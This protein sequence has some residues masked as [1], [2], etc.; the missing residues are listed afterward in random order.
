ML[1]IV[2]NFNE[3]KNSN[4]L[5]LLKNRFD[6]E[7]YNFLNLDQNILNKIEKIFLDQKNT[8]LKIFLWNDKFEEII[9]LF[10]LDNS[11]DILLFLWEN[12]S[13]IPEKISFEYEKDNF[14]LDSIILWKYDFSNYKAEKKQ[15]ELNLLCENSKE[16]FLQDRLSTLK[17][18]TDARDIVNTPSNDKTCDKY[19]RHIKNIKFKNTKVKV[20][21]YEELK[22]SW[23]WLIEA[24]WRSSTSKPKIVILENIIDKRLPTIWLVWKWIIFDTGWLNIK[25]ENYMYWMKDDMA[26]S[27][28]LLYTM[29]ELDDKKLWVNIVCALSI[30]ENSISWDSYR[31]WDILTS[32]SW[33]T[34]EVINTDAEWRL[35]MADWISYLSKNYNLES[36]T[37]L[38]TLTWA[39]MVALWYNYAWVMWDNKELINNLLS[40]DTFEKYWELPFNDFYIEK[41]KWTISDFK[42]LT[43]WIFVWATMWWAFLKNFCLNKEKFTHIDIAW[44]SFVKEKF[45]LYNVWATWFW[46]DSLSKVIINQYK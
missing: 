24:V 26:W 7:K 3:I 2:S 11:Q 19:V 37:T 40:N 23:F 38:A 21:D 27:A 43:E 34:V 20:I 16:V 42:N 44:V 14:L 1:N 17:N 13:K 5:V 28:T 41:T 45:W 12:I 31:P 8:S 4:L 15:L 9:F 36:I 35:V 22:R 30:A 29:K 46:V 10:Y 32:Y 25:T 33:K 39:C 6:L 18:I